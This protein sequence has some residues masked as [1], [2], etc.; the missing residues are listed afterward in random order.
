MER[1]D[2]FTEALEICAS[3]K[4]DKALDIIYNIVDNM[5][6]SARF[7]E[8]DEFI[9]S[10]NVVETPTVIMVG[11]LTITLC[12]WDALPSRATFFKAVEDELV[13]RGEDD[14]RM[15]KGLEKWRLV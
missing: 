14:P 1:T 7:E 13:R 5:L 15:L 9:Q 10:V 8:V 4:C 12:A 11:I 3:G 2:W 6:L